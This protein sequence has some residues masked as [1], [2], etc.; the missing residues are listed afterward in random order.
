MS[1][2]QGGT[3]LKIAVKVTN[4]LTQKVA[5]GSIGFMP[6]ILKNEFKRESDDFNRKVELWFRFSI[7][8]S[9]NTHVKIWVA[10]FKGTLLAC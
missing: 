10:H 7:Q 3:G 5:E 2:R 9:M 4:L 6:K 8:L 1:E